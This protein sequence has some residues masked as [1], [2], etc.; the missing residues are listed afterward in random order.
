M[1]EIGEFQ[2]ICVYRE[3]GKIMKII[4]RAIGGILIRRRR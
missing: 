1:D 2:S 4:D 3:M